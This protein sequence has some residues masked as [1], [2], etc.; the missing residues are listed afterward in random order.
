MPR[1][2]A[3]T[4]LDATTLDIINTI[5]A[6]A[7]Y[8]YQSLV[9]TITQE[10]DI[11][12]V[13][14]ILYGYPALANQFLNA[15]VNRIAAVKV[16]SAVFNNAYAE[17]K[18]GVLEFGET[19]EEVFVGIAKARE[20]SA[21]KAANREFKRTLPDVRSA[22]HIMNW[23]VQYPVTIQNDDLRMAF[24]GMQGV[25]D[26][27]ARIVDQVYTAAEYD[28][29]L[30]FKYLI[31]KAVA[32]GKMKPVAFTGGDMKNAAVAFRGTSNKLTFMS[33]E[34]NSS[35][36][37]TATPKADQFIFMDAAFNA[38]YD[39]NVLAS[40]FNM[41]KADFM[42]RLKLIDDFTTFDNER[43]SEIR[44]N[45]TMIEEV[46]SEEL[47]LMADVK[48]VLVDR[49]WFQIYDNLNQFTEVYVSS[50]LYWNYNYHVWKTVS[51]SPFSNAVVFVQGSESEAPATL[52]FTVQAISEDDHTRV[53]T[54]V[55]DA[56]DRYQFIQ[57]STNTQAGVAIHKYGAVIV[58]MSAIE[59]LSTPLNSS[60]ITLQYMGATYSGSIQHNAVQSPSAVSAT[61]VGDT[62]TFSKQ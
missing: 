62:I 35:G 9:P 11:P 15:L 52:T 5:R 49:E 34:Y 53:Y 21:E 19:V 55:D 59:D 18:K 40:A 17:L 31:I 51:S 32:H 61:A 60:T 12:A 2:I 7:S 47:A 25:Q 36:V 41:D 20:F 54:L 48:A 16:N 56:I 6:N 46:T 1:R 27:I 28:E 22:F 24:T 42:G 10:T 45:S 26:L 38:Q 3:I 23:R 4:N 33:K 13:G 43:F 39:V 37:T 57:D 8:E 50:G 29:F 58:P 30:L 44:N 14:E